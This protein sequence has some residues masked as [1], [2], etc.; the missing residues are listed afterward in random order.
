MKEFGRMKRNLF[1]TSLLV[2]E[3]YV[4]EPVLLWLSSQNTRR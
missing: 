4:E 1:A 3:P 2:G